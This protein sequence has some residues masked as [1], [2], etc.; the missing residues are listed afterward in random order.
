MSK[1]SST[2]EALAVQKTISLDELIEL[3]SAVR[4]STPERNAL[5]ALDRDFEER[6]APGLPQSDHS[7]RRATFAWMLDRRSE[8]A[9]ALVRFKSPVAAFMLGRI[10][11]AEGNLDEAAEHYKAASD[12][13]G[14][15]RATFALVNVLRLQG[16]IKDVE[17]QFAKLEKRYA[18]DSSGWGPAELLHQ[19]GR[20]KELEGDAEGALDLYEQ[21]LEVHPEH[22]ESAFRMGC[23][24]DLRG[25]DDEAI[26]YY[27]RSAVGSRMYTGAMMNVALL[28]EDRGEHERAI[29]CY[30]DVLR[31]EPTSSK[32]RLF[33][34]G[35]IE[36]TE[37][38]YD[39]I[40][41]KEKEKLD[42]V[43]RL[44]VAEF[45]LS[46]RSRNVLQRM[47]IRT[48]GDLVQ[49]SEGE[50]LAYKNFGETSLREMKQLLTARG[51]KIGMGR[52]QVERRH[53]RERLALVMSDQDS[54]RLSTPISELDL[55][56]RSRRCMARLNIQTI[57][58]VITRTEEELLATKNFGQTSLADIRT[59]LAEMGLRLRSS[60]EET[61][62]D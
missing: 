8:A 4:S 57:G 59:K 43:L 39:E 46:V 49:K 52:D 24:F 21:A 1:T 23:I 44:P 18:G 10:A 19:R 5:V 6:V 48:L 41:R 58:D 16:K 25:L 33:L 20:V 37:E 27:G 22:S 40:E 9:S 56:V 53:Q 12:E 11:E 47:N 13:A 30:R 55:S 31:A 14:D 38:V 35:A 26:E 28:Y 7:F 42:Q 51:L 15:P 60:E 62:T 45:E 34:D 32:A 36:S 50:M 2:V 29:A 17:K 54:R 3:A 61:S